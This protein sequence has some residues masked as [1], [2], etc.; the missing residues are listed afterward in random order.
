MN[1]YSENTNYKPVN[2][3][4]FRDAAWQQLTGHWQSAVILSLVYIIIATAVSAIGERLGISLLISIAIYPMAYSYSISFLEN[5]RSGNE[6]R[7]DNLFNEYKSNNFLRIALTILLQQ[8]YTFLWTLLLI[9]P[10]IIKCCSYSQTY[11]VLR[12]NPELQY[13]AAI[14]RSMAMMQGHKMQ[15]FLLLLS[16]IGWIFLI[17]LSLGILSFW[18][19]PYMSCAMA[20]FYEYVKEEYEKNNVQ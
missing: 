4:F 14:E 16:F 5:K 13:N 2:S 12:D 3:K 8:I 11:Y 6:V 9:V 7:I 17:I 15:Y 19:T 10:G 1:T 20:H 18:V